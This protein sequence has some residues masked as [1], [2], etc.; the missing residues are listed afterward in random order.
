MVFAEIRGDTTV[1]GFNRRIPPV[2]QRQALT[3]AFSALNAVV[4][5]TLA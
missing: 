1:N 3:V 4:I 2:V 5:G